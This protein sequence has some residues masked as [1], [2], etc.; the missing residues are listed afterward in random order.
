ME[1]TRG[2]ERGTD[3]IVHPSLRR[4]VSS[5][6]GTLRE[7][8]VEMSVGVAKKEGEVEPIVRARFRLLS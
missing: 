6:L 1:G 2:K 5:Q 4:P 7:K 3:L 8:W